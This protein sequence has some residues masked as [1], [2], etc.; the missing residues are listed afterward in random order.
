MKRKLLIA[1]P[2][3]GLLAASL[4]KAQSFNTAVLYPLNLPSGFAFGGPSGFPQTASEGQVVGSGNNGNDQAL[5]WTSGTATNLNPT[6]L[7]GVTSSYI[8][9]TNG[10]QQVGYGLGTG[11]SNN[12]NALLWSGA[13]NTVINLNPTNISGITSSY[14]YGTNGTQQVGF[15]SG[16]ATSNNDHALLWTGSASTAV[17]LNPTNISTI[18]NSFANYTDGTNQ[19][20][21][22]YGTGTTNNA[23]AL[24]WSGAANT[25]VDLN[26]T[27]LTG[28]T[29]ST[30]NGASGTQEVGYG[31]GTG[32][33]GNDQAMLWTGTAG[34]AVN[35]NPTNLS[36]ISSS[37]AN[38]TNGA[39]QV[40]YGFGSGTNDNTN[41]MLWGGTASSAVNLQSL[42]PSSGTWVFS[43]AYTIDSTGNIFGVAYGTY[44]GTTN[45]YAVEWAVAPQLTWNNSG[46]ASPND[47]MTWDVNN[48]NNWNNGSATTVYTDGSAVTFNDS[49]SGNY[50]VMLNTTVSPASV[51]VNNSS[52]SYTIAGTGK[53]ADA[54][55]FT[56][57]GSS[58]LTLG[59]GLSTSG[60]LI[61]NGNV[62]FAAGTAGGSGPAATSAITVGSLSIAGTSQ[63]DITNNH[64]IVNYGTGTDPIS[65]I[66]AM[67]I[68]G[69]NHG[70]WNGAGIISSTAATNN[71]TPGNLLYGIGYA[72]SA[73]TG[74]PAN[75]SSGTIEIAY[76]LL[77][78]ANLSGVV[79]GT[80]FGIVAA[81]FNKGV[82]GWDQGDFSYDNVV[83]G[84]DF[85]DLAA[86]FNKG[87]SGAAAWQAVVA[88][89]AANGLMADVPEPA[90]TGLLLMAS[91][92]ILA[93]RRRR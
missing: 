63:L 83:D 15:G 19:V 12:P 54:G 68:S 32:T 87:V 6:N 30:A 59:V 37:V 13:A 52:A 77:G 28:I 53:I 22:G 10:S 72:D 5:L 8:I 70:T 67:I 48:N 14:A 4:A 85:G 21:Y 71:A 46:G 92:G 36:G 91:A 82:S 25:A 33:G 45:S 76:T 31:L 93:R 42:L 16:T 2:M 51:T 11:T 58:N 50:S 40:G 62:Q 57:T 18:S 39:E 27:N 89:A 7:S 81:N 60:L 17:D 73:D 80:D 34:S 29:V 78:D 1:V 75:L 20:G 66:T 69:Y 23:H 41:A 84:T 56:K 86:N 26:P 79:D 55:T 3:T 61:Q 90:T 65:S 74:N 43:E 35:L 88:F 24:L 38:S 9:G 44:N 47:G 64:M 49:N